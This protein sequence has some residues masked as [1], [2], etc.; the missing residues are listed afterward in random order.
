MNTYRNRTVTTQ[1]YIS[2]P[3]LWGKRPVYDPLV[4][5]YK[6]VSP[7]YPLHSREQVNHLLSILD[8]EWVVI[9]RSQG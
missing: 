7:E 6:L 2:E 5:Q 3:R 8:R 9:D 4:D 1:Q